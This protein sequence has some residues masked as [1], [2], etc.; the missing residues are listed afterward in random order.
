MQKNRQIGF[1]RRIQ[2]EWL[3][4][5]ANLAMA[6]NDRQTINDALQDFLKDKLSGGNP[7]VRGSREKA[8]TILMKTWVTV[9]AELR[10]FR[11]EG[12]EYL[13]RL[14]SEKHL[15]L[16]WGMCMATYGFF[17]KAATTMGRMLRLQD[18]FNA[19]HIQR[20]LQEIYGQRDA[21]HYATERILRT[22]VDWDI[23]ADADRKGNYR[24]NNCIEVESPELSTWLIEAYLANTDSGS[25]EL[26]TVLNAPAFFP[27]KL[28]PPDVNALRKH[29]RIHYGMHGINKP[30]LSLNNQQEDSRKRGSYE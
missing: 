29:P 20:R 3:D 7:D 18:S 11:D 30:V 23:L 16:H 28:D 26:D 2:L 10:N 1:N 25:A 21:L 22:M 6:G 24:L 14:P 17:G 27:F 5:V 8:I 19:S 12:F 13:Q 9:P 4:R 15:P